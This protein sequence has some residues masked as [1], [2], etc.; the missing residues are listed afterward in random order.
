MLVKARPA[1]PAWLALL[2]YFVV[3]DLDTKGKFS[4]ILLWLLFVQFV[5]QHHWAV[6]GPES[7]KLKLQIN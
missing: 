1:L 2:F 6:A 4:S 7:D 5:E 3:Q